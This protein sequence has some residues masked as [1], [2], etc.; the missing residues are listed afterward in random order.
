MVTG[1]FRT[2][3]FDGRKRL[4]AVRALVPKNRKSL[5]CQKR[6]IL[7]SARSRRNNQN[8]ATAGLSVRAITVKK[9]KSPAVGRL[10]SI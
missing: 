5:K 10:E 9:A 4:G 1:Q 8:G 2:N 3:G 6:L 7:D